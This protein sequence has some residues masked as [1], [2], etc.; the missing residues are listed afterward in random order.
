MKHIAVF[1]SA[2]E[3]EDEFIQDAKEFAKLIVEHGYGLIW[4]GSDRGLMRVVARSVKEAGG[5]IVGVSLELLKEYAME[6]AHE[7]IITKDF[8]ER[9]AAML[10]R[11]DAIAVLAG[12]LGTLDEI[13]EVLELKKHNLHSKPVLILNTAHFYD[14][15]KM[16]LQQIKERGFI[17]RSL[18]ELVYFSDTPSDAIAYLNKAFSS[19]Q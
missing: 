12:G 3:L 5:R 14:G 17:K 18:D 15:L 13:T 2:Q 10:Q 6:D 16:Q 11:C 9:K 1:C 4:G 19:F 7:M 8:S